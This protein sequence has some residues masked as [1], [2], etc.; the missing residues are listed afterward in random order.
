MTRI[1]ISGKI[2]GE[3]IA[4]CFWKFHYAGLDVEIMMLKLGFD[5][6]VIN[7]LDMPG[8]NFGEKYTKYIHLC[9][10]ALKTCTHIYMLKDW[11]KSQGA[12]KEHA[13]AKK[14]GLK[15]IYQDE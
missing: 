7:P 15:I 8:V 1:F 2:S 5:V 13:F 9:N 4:R 3:Q 10:E 14:L 11:E 12:K 6:E